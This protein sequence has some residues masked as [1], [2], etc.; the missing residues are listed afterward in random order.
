MPAPRGLSG[1]LRVVGLT[2]AVFCLLVAVPFGFACG[3]GG[4]RAA[5]E[6]EAGEPNGGSPAAADAGAGGRGNAEARARPSGRRSGGTAPAASRG[7]FVVWESNRSGRWRIWIRDLAGGVPRQL[8]ADEKGRNH[9]CPHVAPSGDR[10][11]YLSHQGGDRE[12]D[13]SATTGE[14]RLIAPDGGGQRTIAPAARTYFENRAVVWRSDDELIFIDGE[15]HTAL[16]NVES[17]K[18]RRLTTRPHERW[19]WLID[20]E[21]STAFDGSATFSPFDRASGRVAERAPFGGCE[22]FV[23]ADGRWGYWVAGAGGPINRIELATRE[24][25]TILRKNDPRLPGAWGYMYFP[26]VSRDGRM[27][28]WAASQNRHDHFTEDYEVFVAELDPERLELTGEPI[29]ITEHPRTDR[30]PDVWQPPL[31]LGRHVGEAPFRV[32]FEAPETG[33]WR[34]DLGDGATASGSAVEHLYERP[35]A[36]LVTAVAG[37]RR[38]H[39]EVVV[40]PARPP[41]VVEAESR[42]SGR[43]LHLVF[44]EP[45]DAAGA[46]VRLEPGPQPSRLR[47]SDDGR[48]LIAELE[49][50]LT[51]PARVTVA[52]VHDRAQQPN[53]LEGARL[54]VQPPRWPA[55]REGLFFLWQTADAPNLV[56]DAQA[57]AD[58]AV[59]LEPAGQAHLDHDHAMV[60]TGGSFAAAGEMAGRLRRALQATNELT[61][62]LVIE[63]AAETTSGFRPIVSFTGGNR[64]NFRLGQQGEQLV[65]FLGAAPRGPGAHIRLP[66]FRIPVGEKTHVAVTYAPDRTIAYRNG[67]KMVDTDEVRGDFFHW[68]DYPLLFGG[69]PGGGPGWSGTLEGV[70]IYNRVLAAEEIAEDARRYLDLIAERSPVRQAVVEA[71]LVARSR[72]PTLEEITPY[73]EALV[74][75]EYEVLRVVSGEAPSRLRAAHWALLDGQAQPAASLRVGEERRLTLEPYSAN[76]QLESLVLSDT[77]D[78]AAGLPLFYVVGP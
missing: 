33:S 4:P 78:G 67:E 77:L 35:G 56:Y 11:A 71:R 6:G 75:Y 28:A 5:A 53:P 10:I 54:T 55:S 48:T 23:T 69:G 16:L 46:T 27:L 7:G 14:L 40:E 50:P 59:T 47:Q 25:S 36:F 76:S 21:L 72:L 22:P 44:D 8:T 41:R 58:R 37:D 66:L 29:R 45:I 12:Y 60:V 13:R 74:A 43:E 31:P 30:F 42:R 17:G 38:L 3:E 19:G 62:E 15:R 34:W 26:M 32:R 2:A 57:E 68:R 49:S 65:F 51:R 20:P 70:A 63:P 61:L 9:C 64:E 39:G 1:S 24:V 73:R 52:G 18:S